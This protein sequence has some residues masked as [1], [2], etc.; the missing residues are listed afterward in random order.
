MS[1]SRQPR[2]LLRPLVTNKRSAGAEQSDMHFVHVGGTPRDVAMKVVQTQEEDNSFYVCD[3]RELRN[4][5]RLWRQELP[6]VVPHYAIKACTDPVVIQ[7]L[8]CEEVNFDC[9]NKWEIEVLVNAGIDVTRILYANPA[10][11]TSHL[12]FAKNVG[13]TLMTFDCAEELEKI[14][15]KKARLLLRIRAQG[16]S[17]E[18]K[19]ATKYGCSLEETASL[20][21]T[22]SDLGQ[23][24]V[25]V[26]FHVGAI[27]Y[28]PDTFTLAIAQAREVFDIAK[29]LG[30]EMNVLDIGGGFPGGIRTRDSFEKVCQAVRN[31]LDLHFPES[32][33]ISVI[34]EPGQ[35]MVTAPYTLAAKVV[36]KRTQQT[37]IDGTLC[38]RHD[39]YLNASK[40]NCIPR[41]MYTFLDIRLPAALSALQPAPQ[42]FDDVVGRH[43]SSFGHA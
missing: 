6:R 16:G 38:Y 25:G 2:T 29:E 40:E 35:Y 32:S 7:T 18:C 26:A 37:S 8:A 33:G 5:V 17:I 9:S 36:A 27:H 10:K 14:S 19:M 1:E 13:V 31:A 39:V 41:E 43:V 21:R 42:I 4:R 22:A 28:D 30:M 15:D 23:S 20:L 12:E 34:A 24:V 11:Q 3:L